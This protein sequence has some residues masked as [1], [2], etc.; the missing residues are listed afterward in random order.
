MGI[1]NVP[2]C[3]TTKYQQLARTAVAIYNYHE[4]AHLTFV[5]NLNC[6][7]QGNYYYITLAATDDAGK[8]AI[9]EAKIG[10]VESA[11][12]TGVEEFK[13]V[14]SLEGSHHHHHH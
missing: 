11:G 1:V 12:W 6:K 9:Y 4:Q 5:E 7:E 10:V 3:N 13:L 14:G 8:K 2:N